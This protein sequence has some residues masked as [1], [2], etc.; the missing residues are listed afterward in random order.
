MR[1]VSKERVVSIKETD[2]KTILKMVHKN[3]LDI[4]K[5]FDNYCKKNNLKYYMIGGTFLGSI[6]HKGFIPWDDDMDIAMPREDYE[7]FLKK[8]P[9]DKYLI[10]NY[11]THPEYKYYIS[12]LC[13]KKYVIK[14]KTG[15]TVNLFV[16]IFPIDGMPNNKLLKKIHCLRILYHRM[17]LSFFYNDTIDKN[18]KR[19]FYEKILIVLATRIPFKKLINPS[20]EKYKI[21]KLLMKYSFYKSNYS[22]TIMGA[23]RERE[24]VKTKLFGQPTLYKFEDTKLYGPERFDE[25]L[26][27]IYGDYMSLPPKEKQIC[28]HIDEIYIKE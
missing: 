21:D 27:H 13:S 25:Y 17:K 2:E 19:K 1:K 5:D 22:G 7:E 23:Y 28:G 16:D 6:R 24:I 14:E 15:N 10:L 11:K 9:Q 20:K 12:K 18:K 26:T 3:A 8:Y 4:A